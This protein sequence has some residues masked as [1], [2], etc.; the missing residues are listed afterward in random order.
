MFKIMCNCA[1]IYF[2][3]FCFCCFQ[4][5][6]LVASYFV[7]LMVV[8]FLELQ[9]SQMFYPEFHACTCILKNLIKYM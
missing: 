7:Y 4:M 1:S 9:I 2:W 6:S 3:C 8:F 5:N